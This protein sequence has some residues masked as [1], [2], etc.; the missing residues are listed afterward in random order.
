MGVRSAFKNIITDATGA[1]VGVAGG[2]TPAELA[3][4]QREEARRKAAEPPFYMDVREVCE[5]VGVKTLQEFEQAQ[6]FACG[7]PQPNPFRRLVSDPGVH[8]GIRPDSMFER[9]QVM[10][11]VERM[12]PIAEH[13]VRTQKRGR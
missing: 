10:R 3:E 2:P 11:W 6:L 13:L 5:L 9:W 4:L 8:G 7:F 1:F 12:M